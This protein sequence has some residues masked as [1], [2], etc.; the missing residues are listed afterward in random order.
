MDCWGAEVDP[1]VRVRRGDDGLHVRAIYGVCCIA[2]KN[3]RRFGRRSMD[4][5]RNW[6]G[7]R[8]SERRERI[9]G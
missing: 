8:I 6:G 1:V 4:W 5:R 2:E 7:K 9:G 3:N